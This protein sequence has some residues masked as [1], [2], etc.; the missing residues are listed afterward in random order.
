MCAHSRFPQVGVKQPLS[1]QQALKCMRAESTP[2]DE[3][4]V[5]LYINLR[6]QFVHKLVL[7]SCYTK[8]DTE[9][10]T[11]ACATNYLLDKT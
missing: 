9:H 8:R 7:A 1:A 3:I 5:N 10:H 4:V 2:V 11:G 6:T